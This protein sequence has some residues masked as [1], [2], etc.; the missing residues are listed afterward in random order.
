MAWGTSCLPAFVREIA[1][2]SLGGWLSRDKPPE[3]LLCICEPRFVC[4]ACSLGCAPCPEWPPPGQEAPECPSAS[5]A[6][7]G[8]GLSFS[9]ALG[10]SGLLPLAFFAGRLKARRW[11][12]PRRIS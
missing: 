3:G 2:A 6:P 4:P 10:S 8:G 7:S 5:E 1:A 11:R 12:P 9:V